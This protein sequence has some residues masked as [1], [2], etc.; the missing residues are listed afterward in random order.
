MRVTDFS[1]IEGEFIRRVHTM[2]W[3]SVASVDSQGRPRSRIL[4]PIWE[5]ATGWIGTHPD[6][7]SPPPLCAIRICPRLRR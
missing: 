1:E 7:Q 6:S 4:H 5:G 3:C 2:V